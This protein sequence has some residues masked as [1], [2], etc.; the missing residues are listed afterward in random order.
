MTAVEYLIKNLVELGYILPSHG[1][2]N[3]FKNIVER[4]KEMEIERDDKLKTAIA[5]YMWSE[6]CS[7]CEGDDHKE[8]KDRIGELL[9]IPKYSDDSGYDFKN[10]RTQEA[11]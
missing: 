1:N 6:G 4:A 2:H 5:D 11:E 8:H 10:F 9:N 7:C 3:M